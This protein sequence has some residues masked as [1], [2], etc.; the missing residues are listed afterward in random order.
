MAYDATN[1]QKRPVTANTFHDADA[2]GNLSPD[3]NDDNHEIQLMKNHLYM[4]L[5][6]HIYQSIDYLKELVITPDMYLDK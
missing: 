2:D 3:E 5:L 4:E 6:I 1:T